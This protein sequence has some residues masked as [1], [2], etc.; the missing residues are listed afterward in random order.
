MLLC[1]ASSLP[2]GAYSLDCGLSEGGTKRDVEPL[3]NDGG[4]NVARDSDSRADTLGVGRTDGRGVNG[5][6]VGGAGEGATVGVVADEGGR[7]TE[8]DVGVVR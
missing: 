2:F 8:F 1:L 3:S 6:G 5:F 4:L 7:A